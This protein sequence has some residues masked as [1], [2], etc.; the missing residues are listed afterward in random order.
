M[1]NNQ[2][3]LITGASGAIAKSIIA[4]LNT[5]GT[6]LYL[7]DRPSQTIRDSSIGTS[8]MADLSTFEG[9]K[10]AI[11]GIIQAHGRLDGVIHTVG[12]FAIESILEYKSST[13]DQMLDS[14]LRSTVNI[15][16]AATPELEKSKGFFGAIA[17]GQVIRGAG[18]NLALYTAAKGALA[19]FI[20]S[21]SAEIKTVRYGVV[22]PMGTIDTPTNRKN[23][24]NS[25]TSTWISPKEIAEAFA[26]M[27]TRS[28]G[29]RVQEVQVFPNA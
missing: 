7:L 25:D 21:L 9:A 10:A 15:A 3:Y 19:L 16:A 20:K 26:Y 27:A 14:N 8:I 11:D 12:G 6:I 24:P 18:A 29:G 23:M 2:I 1:L 4:K 5:L 22:Y 28:S 17:A 13:Y